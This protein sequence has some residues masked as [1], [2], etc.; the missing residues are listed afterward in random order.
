MRKASANCAN[1]GNSP[2][3][4]PLTPMCLKY[5]H[6]NAVAASPIYHGK[7]LNFRKAI[8]ICR[9]LALVKLQDAKLYEHWVNR[10]YALTPLILKV[11]CRVVLHCNPEHPMSFELLNIAN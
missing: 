5:H 3:G 2:A 11:L 1:Y 8:R 10:D 4:P 6:K 9:P 7:W